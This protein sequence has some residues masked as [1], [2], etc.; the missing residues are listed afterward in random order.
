MPVSPEYREF[1]LEQL[2]CVGP[3]TG[4]SMFGGLGIYLDGVFFALIASD[5]LY[6]KVD[7]ATRGAYE[8]AGMP[9]FKPYRNRSMTMSYHEVPAEVL[10]DAAQLREWG[11]RAV[12]VARRSG[13]PVRTGHGNRRRS[14]TAGM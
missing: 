4:R 12:A 11:L 5:V 8:A 10:E 7:D 14:P 13:K 9:A 3:V 2:A 6:F 1:V